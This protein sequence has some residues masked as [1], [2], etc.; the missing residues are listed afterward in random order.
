MSAL[1]PAH[2]HLKS[3]MLSNR[4]FRAARCLS[5]RGDVER[6]DV[7]NDLVDGVNALLHREVELVVVRFQVLGHR[8]GSLGGKARYE[9]RRKSTVHA[10]A[11]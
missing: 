11:G 8:G 5:H 9:P 7:E 4:R 2:T 3:A 6:L 1:S 10:N